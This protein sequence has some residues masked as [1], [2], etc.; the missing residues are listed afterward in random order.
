M[1]VDTEAREAFIGWI[2]EIR[3]DYFVY[4]FSDDV[5]CTIE[6]RSYCP[7]WLPEGSEE[8]YAEDGSENATILYTDADG[9]FIKFYYADAPNY[10]DLFVIS[11]DLEA[12][13]TFANGQPAIF[14]LSHDLEVSSALLWTEDH[15]AFYLHAFLEQ[16]ELTYMAE[17]VYKIKLI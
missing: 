9:Y 6:R 13:D 12:I 3:E 7:G 4:H 10:S 1:T 14:L 11:D 5:G 16:D 17:S 2:P 15:I 8:F